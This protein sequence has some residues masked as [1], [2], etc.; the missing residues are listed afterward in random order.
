MG[1]AEEVEVVGHQHVGV[2]VDLEAPE[3]FGCEVQEEHSITVGAVQV[4]FVGAAV[5]DVLPFAAAEVALM[6]SHTP[7]MTKACD[8]D[9]VAAVDRWSPAFSGRVRKDR[10][11]FGV[12]SGKTGRTRWGGVSRLR[13]G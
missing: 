4:L 1:R 7:I 5:A 8:R 13:S 11:S 12:G 9:D 6:S 3:R 10:R 2:Q